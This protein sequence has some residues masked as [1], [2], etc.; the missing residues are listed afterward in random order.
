[1]TNHIFVLR[2]PHSSIVCIRCHEER[3][4]GAKSDGE[5]GNTFEE[6]S[7]LKLHPWQ[8]KI[9]D[10]IQAEV[11]NMQQC[12]KCGGIPCAWNCACPEPCF[13]CGEDPCAEDCARFPWRP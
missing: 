9:F 8:Q 4:E 1:M 11:M 12:T 6:E 13:A 5:C 7:P 10:E 3:P 2:Y